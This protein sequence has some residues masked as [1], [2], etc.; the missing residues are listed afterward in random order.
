MD[1]PSRPAGLPWQRRASS[2]SSASWTSSGN[3]L[4]R[5][6]TRATRYRCRN[7]SWTSELNTW[8]T[9]SSRGTSPTRTWRGLTRQVL[10]YG[11][12]KPTEFII[13]TRKGGDFWPHNPIWP[14]RWCRALIGAEGLNRLWRHKPE[15]RDFVQQT[16]FFN[17]VSLCWL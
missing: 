4:W 8:F 10:R 17:W 11:S 1:K 13:M 14:P 12:E 6:P 5:S 2:R 15:I 7:H 9:T 16:V 3:W